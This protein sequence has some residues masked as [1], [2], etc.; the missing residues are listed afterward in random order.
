MIAMIVVAGALSACTA[1]SPQAPPT[2]ESVASETAAPAPEPAR[3]LIGAETA[4]IVD[5]GGNVLLSLRYSENGDGAVASAIDILGEPQATHHQDGSNHY[6]EMEGTSW[7]GFDVRS[8][9][10]DLPTSFPGIVADPGIDMAYG[11]I[12]RSDQGSGT[13]S[14]IVAPR[15]LFSQA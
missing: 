5:D 14:T 3:I 6:P 11:V 13:I 8:V 7:G 1:A 15:F 10:L 4:D 9:A 2:V 12:G